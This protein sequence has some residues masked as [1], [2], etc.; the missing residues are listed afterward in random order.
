MAGSCGW[1]TIVD[2]PREEAEV[3]LGGGETHVLH[4]IRDQIVPVLRNF[5]RP[6]SVLLM[7]QNLSGLESG[8]PRGGRTVLI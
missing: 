7:I 6:Y 8:F 4:N 5:H 2:D 3:V 1:C